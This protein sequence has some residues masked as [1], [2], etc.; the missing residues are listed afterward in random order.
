VQPLTTYELAAI[1]DSEWRDD[2]N[3]PPAVSLVA[4]TAGGQVTAGRPASGRYG[5]LADELAEAW[6]SLTW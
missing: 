6:W 5:A 2:L 3:E 1:A 4:V